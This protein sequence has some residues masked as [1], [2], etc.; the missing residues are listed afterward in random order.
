MTAGQQ[1]TDAAWAERR[2]TVKLVVAIPC[3]NE[4]RTVAKVISAVPVPFSRVG[5][6]EVVVIDDGSTDATVERARSA[7]AAVVSHGANLGLGRA[8]REAVRQ[9]L[10]RGADILVTIDGDGQFDPAD[11]S[12]L[13]QPILDGEAHMVTA[14][15]F[16]RAALVPEMPAI[17]KWGNRRVAGIVRTLTGK[18]FHDVSCGF[19][20]FSRE[21]LLKMN[22]FGTFTYTQETFLDLIFKGLTIHEMPVRVRGTREFGSSR[23]A[24]GLTRYAVRSLQI[25]RALIAASSSGEYDIMPKTRNATGTM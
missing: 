12:R 10:A 14:S 23:I 11:I 7:G 1:G 19:R 18:R 22:L 4:E 8:F 20:A 5:S 15:R 3:L 24:S 2:G 6:V 17:K 13:V 21:A 9:A 16:A 25:F